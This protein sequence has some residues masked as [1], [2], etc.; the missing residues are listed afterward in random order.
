MSS[1]SKSPGEPRP[2]LAWRL[3]ILQAKLPPAGRLI[4]QDWLASAAHRPA[5]KAAIWKAISAA[6]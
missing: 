2:G 6:G 4:L 3:L 1:R 5:R